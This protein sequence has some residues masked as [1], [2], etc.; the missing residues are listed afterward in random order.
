MWR[1]CK[2][3]L[4]EKYF[5][6]KMISLKKRKFCKN[7]LKILGWHW[8]PGV[9]TAMSLHILPPPKGPLLTP[10]SNTSNCT[11]H[12]AAA[13]LS[14]HPLPLPH[15][16]PHSSVPATRNHGGSSLVRQKVLTSSSLQGAKQLSHLDTRW[17][18][19]TLCPALIFENGFIQVTNLENISG[20]LIFTEA[21]LFLQNLGAVD[22][23]LF[24]YGPSVNLW[25]AGNPE[26]IT[27]LKQ[28]WIRVYWLDR[29]QAAWQPIR[30]KPKI[31][32]S[33][34]SRREICLNL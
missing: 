18:C 22:F 1:A 16:H 29:V 15:S 30:K 26:F 24:F 5:Y 27:D 3:F 6:W 13:H 2:H 4:W 7:F 14:H 10:H 12:H 23:R 11:L 9:T 32:N 34:G 17:C 21:K 19:S 31:E 33:V 20:L 25:T 28:I 8:Q